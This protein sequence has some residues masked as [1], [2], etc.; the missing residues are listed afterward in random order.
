MLTEKSRLTELY[1]KKAEEGTDAA[2][3]YFGEAFNNF[4]IRNSAQEL[5]KLLGSALKERGIDIADGAE[6][7]EGTVKD[8]Y[9]PFLFEKMGNTDS[10]RVSIRNWLLRNKPISR[11]SAI[12]ILLALEVDDIDSAN[13]F[14]M[15]TCGDDA[16]VLYAR[17]YK[18]VIYTF[19]LKKRYGVDGAKKLINKH[20]KAIEFSNYDLLS[21]VLT[22]LTDDEDEIEKAI[23]AITGVDITG[24]DRH[25]L[26]H[27][28]YENERKIGEKII[29]RLC[30][31]IGIEREKQEQAINKYTNLLD[32]ILDRSK[33][34][35]ILQKMV[36]DIETEP[37]LDDYLNTHKDSFGTYRRTAYKTF[38]EYYKLL[39]NIIPDTVRERIDD[40]WLDEDLS[41][42]G[43]YQMLVRIADDANSYV[44]SGNEI[45]RR[46]R[47]STLSLIQEIIAKG[48][49]MD[50]TTLKDIKNRQIQVP[51]K[52]LISIFMHTWGDSDDFETPI[53]E[54]N[55]LLK[56]CGM[57]ML[58]SRNP[59]DFL[60]M[61]SIYWEV[62]N[63]DQNKDFYAIDRVKAIVK[64]VFDLEV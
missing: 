27:K 8:I 57:P 7:S 52:Y 34:T 37:Q 5:K 63:N 30:D 47:T 29:R 36:D 9:I 28:L 42:E 51:R 55:A 31:N 23:K 12:N 43:V 44:P 49:A 35:R 41:I 13:R 38:I 50:D 15:R 24:D 18:D 16:Y 54:L 39:L 45:R 25:K 1:E 20:K 4:E 3:T 40:K 21:S 26:L 60:I 56:E 61:N 17:D 10:L 46:T 32:K 64:G 58:D 22:G 11:Q 6:E 19:C 53:E 59:F 62:W 2:L 33:E 14:I 48:T